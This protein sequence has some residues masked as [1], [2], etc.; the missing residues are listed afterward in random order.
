MDI[1]YTSRLTSQTIQKGIPILRV[2]I[3][4]TGSYT[5]KKVQLR[6]FTCL[7]VST[8]EL[9]CRSNQHAIAS[10]Q[11]KLKLDLSGVRIG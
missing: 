2:Q 9:L 7:M 8:E 11:L 4:Q 10:S 5:K 6:L 1:R 3:R